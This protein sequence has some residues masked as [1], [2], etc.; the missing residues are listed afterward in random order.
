MITRQIIGS[1]TGDIAG[2]AGDPPQHE[3]TFIVLNAAGTPFLA[4][5]DILDSDGNRFTVPGMVL[6]SD[7]NAFVPLEQ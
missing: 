7:G 3:D 4:S 5:R 6:D 1:I 2:A